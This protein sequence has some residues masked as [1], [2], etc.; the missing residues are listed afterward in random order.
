MYI[1]PFLTFYQHDLTH[2]TFSQTKVRTIQTRN[3]Y[4]EKTNIHHIWLKL[5]VF[6]LDIRPIAKRRAAG[7]IYQKSSYPH[8]L[9]DKYGI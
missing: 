7:G 5:T 9:I 1:S 4:S 2:G 3:C 8:M 6:D